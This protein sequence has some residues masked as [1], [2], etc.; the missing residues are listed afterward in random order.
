MRTS[1]VAVARGRR[2][3]RALVAALAGCALWLAAAAGANAANDTYVEPFDPTAFTAGL[4]T[5]ADSARAD[6]ILT[7][8]TR[9]A[10]TTWWNTAKNYDAQTGTYLDFGGIAEYDIRPPA[11]EAYALATALATGQYDAAAT[12]VTEAAARTIAAKLVRSLAYRHRA[13]TTGGWGDAW[14]SA[15]WAALAGTAGWMLWDDLTASDRELVRK[16]VQHEANRFIGWTVPYLRNRSGTLLRSC[17]DTAAEE[18][19]WNARLLYLAPT[20]MPQHS[21]RSGWTYKAN[22]LSIGAFA[23]PSDLSSTTD[24]RG[25]P[26]TDWL[27]GTNV[28]DDGSLLNHGHY[29]PDYMSTISEQISGGLVRALGGAAVPSNVLRGSERNYDAMVDKQWWP[30][31]AV[32]CPGGRAFVAPTAANPTGTIY[33]DGSPDIYYPHGPESGSLR[34]AAFATLDTMMRQFGRDGLVAQKADYW[35]DL[36]ADIVLRSQ[37]RPLAGGAPSDGSTYRSSSEFSYTGR[38]EW[39]AARAAEAWS[40]KWL[41]HQRA[42]TETNAADQ[43]VIDNADRGVSVAGTWTLGNPAGNGPQVFGPSVRYKAAGTGAGYVRFTPRMTQTRTYRVYAWWNA[44]PAQATNAPYTISHA[45][46][47]S[48]VTKN[49]QATGGQ[50]VLLGSWSMGPGSYVQLSD[51]ANGYVVADGIL[52]DP[53]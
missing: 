53:S 49:Q 27:E 44:A 35:E 17:G 3:T 8:A 33:I 36:H 48:V 9:Y 23:S 30:A 11:S 29:Q 21:R 52:L 7:N 20:M 22:E 18:S 4:P 15:Y 50:W 34:Q 46:G 39:V 5:D 6:A 28:D 25:R 47:T 51:D 2:R 26:L 43:I 32:A 19:A 42:L 14:Q 37:Q 40:T 12:G 13:T 31:P 41:G 38:E 1:K 16:M 45:G 24:V 10:V